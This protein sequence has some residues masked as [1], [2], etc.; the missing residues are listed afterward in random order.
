MTKTMQDKSA[1][2]VRKGTVPLTSTKNVDNPAEQA[3]LEMDPKGLSSFRGKG[4]YI[5]KGY[6]VDVKG[7]GKARKQKATWY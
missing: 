7:T 3:N 6:T 5:G 2:I 4:V 1:T